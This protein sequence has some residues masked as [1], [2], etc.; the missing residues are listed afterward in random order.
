MSWRVTWRYIHQQDHAQFQFTHPCGCDNLPGFNPHNIVVSIHAPVWVRL[1]G[2]YYNARLDLFQ[3][4]HPCGC[5]WCKPRGCGR[6]WKFQFTHPCGCD[7]Y[8]E[9]LGKEYLVSIHAPVW[10]RRIWNNGSASQ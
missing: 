9:K 1:S 6:F 7:T 8:I 3:F 2:T 10:V 5:D 4:T